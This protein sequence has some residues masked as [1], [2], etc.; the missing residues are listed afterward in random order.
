VQVAETQVVVLGAA[1][2]L[3]VGVK[4]ELHDLSG[5]PGTPAAISLELTHDPGS[6][7]LD[8]SF[9]LA[10]PG[11]D[12]TLVVAKLA[13]PPLLEPVAAGPAG[14]LRAG[15]L[16]ADLKLGVG[17]PA[18]AG[19][20]LRL[21]GRIVLS[22]FDAN[23]GDAKSFA[24]AW[25]EL[26]VVIRKLTIRDVRSP[27]VDIQLSLDRL[28]LAEPQIQLTRGETGLV[29]PVTAAA[30]VPQNQPAVSPTP[31]P[32]PQAAPPPAA[33]AATPRVKVDVERL[34]VQR[35]QLRVVDNSVRPVYRAA[36]DSI[37]LRASRLR[38][39]GPS[40]EQ[41]KLDIRGLDGAVLRVSGTVDAKSSQLDVKLEGLPLVAFNPYAAG[42]GYS[43]AHGSASL[44]SSV[45]LRGDHYDSSSRLVL[46]QL[47][48]K[49]GEGETLFLQRF[50]VPLSLALALMRD[51][52][53]D[54]ALTLPISR[55]PS[56]TKV[57]FAAIIGDALAKAIL[58]AIMSPL[59]LVA[60]VTEIGGKVQDVMPVPIAFTPGRAEI[61]AAEE[62]RVDQLASLLGSAPSL[63]LH[64]TGV[65]TAE[66]TRWLKEQALRAELERTSGVLGTLKNLGERSARE[67]ARTYF[68]AQ[69]EGRQAAIPAEHQAWF[70]KKVDE[71]A[72]GE[73]ELRSLA[74]A[75]AREVQARLVREDRVAVERLVLDPPSLAAEGKPSVTIQF[76]A[77]GH[78]AP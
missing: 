29:L 40:A 46:H 11:F 75:R 48:V 36:L 41:V 30:G 61:A 13:L 28:R 53:G 21:S 51:L 69:A 26:E 45:Q 66:D 43:V 73:A 15:S 39:P 31:E 19:D 18:A 64:L 8:G 57:G 49:G 59:K 56:G 52:H 62:P 60:A 63:E 50:G 34:E 1:H 70:D 17:A 71:Q 2:P 67:A 32:V 72:V 37:D 42:T 54:I 33:G 9:T 16:D 14:L 68:A 65:A 77:A 38:W 47:D 3:D 12:G 58:G 78:A 7:V 27:P 24:I 10:P 25:R 44:E 22:G 4:A 55:D 74:E 20:D 5:T 76:G 35:G 23:D 6:I